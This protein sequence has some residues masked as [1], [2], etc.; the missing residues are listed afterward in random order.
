MI[1]KNLTSDTQA[2]TIKNLVGDKEEYVISLQG[3]GV[4]EV[5]NHYEILGL[6][7][8]VVLGILKVV[9]IANP[10]S[11]H[12]KTKEPTQ[13]EETPAVENSEEPQQDSTPEEVTT[14]PVGEEPVGEE[15]AKTPTV[16]TDNFVCEVCKAEFASARGLT[17]HKNRAHPVQSSTN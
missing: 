9:D 12:I 13:D 4:T 5:D 14:E 2:L 7:R 6:E 11:R 17:A 15:V 10:S 1:I 3:L 16:V 8:L